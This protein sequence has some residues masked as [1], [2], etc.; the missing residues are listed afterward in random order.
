[1]LTFHIRSFM[2]LIAFCAVVLAGATVGMRWAFNRA[3]GAMYAQREM[4]HTFEAANFRHAAR[5]AQADPNGVGK[6]AG[7]KQ[8]ARQHEK[9]ARECA[10]LRE[11]YESRW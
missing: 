5:Q 7:F 6:I 4:E 1:M 2:I 9:A 8:L 3:E 10:R 11:L